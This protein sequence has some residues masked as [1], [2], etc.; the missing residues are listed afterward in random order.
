MEQKTNISHTGFI[1]K[2]HEINAK[3]SKPRIKMT[4]MTKIALLFLR[5]YIIF[6]VIMLVYK[7]ITILYGGSFI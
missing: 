4:R 3:Y 6:L 5:L 1:A 7:F 2:I